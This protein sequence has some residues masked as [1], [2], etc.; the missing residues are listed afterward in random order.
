MG[1]AFTNTYAI[2]PVKGDELALDIKMNLSKSDIR[3]AYNHEKCDD[4]ARTLAAINLFDYI[5]EIDFDRALDQAINYAAGAAWAKL[6][7]NQDGHLTSEQ[8]NR[9]IEDAMQEM[10]PFIRH[11]AGRFGMTRGGAWS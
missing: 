2:N 1:H 3:S 5:Q 10:A 4:E 6:D 9:L 11:H 8:I 7:P